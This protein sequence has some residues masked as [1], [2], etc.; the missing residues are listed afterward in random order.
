MPGRPPEGLPQAAPLTGKCH[1][2]RE[3]V[4]WIGLGCYGGGQTCY[5]DPAGPRRFVGNERGIRRHSGAPAPAL[6]GAPR[7]T[8]AP[9]ATH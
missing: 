7:G 3:G 9:S 8:A 4:V 1:G 5:S 6:P 2:A